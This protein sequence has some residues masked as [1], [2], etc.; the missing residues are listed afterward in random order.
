MNYSIPKYSF[1]IC[2]DSVE[3]AL[4]AAAGGAHRLEL[5]DNLIAG[6]TTPSLGML[7]QCK[8]AVD[9]PV[10]FMIRP[11]GGDFLYSD[12]EFEV[13]KQD[14]LLAK[15]AG[16][17]GVVFGILTAEGEV[18]KERN[19]L[20]LN[21]ARP[22]K[23]T[24]HRAFDMAKDPKQALEALIEIGFDLLL[25]SGLEAN[26]DLGTPLL[27]E[28]VKQADKRIQI[29]AGAGVNSTNVEQLI[30]TTG[31]NHIHASASHSLTS[32]MKY[33]NPRLSM[34]QEGYDE[35][36]LNQTSLSK[37]SAILK[38]AQ[39]AWGKVDEDRYTMDGGR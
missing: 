24:F 9:L 31:V 26:V 37:V 11:R 4:I 34:G 28:L 7:Q 14:I 32:S 1:E 10:M 19:Q 13:M 3:S 18:D 6:G 23:C 15:E 39:K 2:I 22:M 16:A 5:C 12:Q 36:S 30:L 17:E 8:K 20:L 35:F 29:M 33:R 25:T 27:I 38:N 21:L